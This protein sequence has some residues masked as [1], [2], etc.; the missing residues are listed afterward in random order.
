MQLKIISWNLNG[1]LSYIEN[2]SFEPIRKLNPD[3]VFLQ[4]TRTHQKPVIIDGYKHVFNLAQKD[5]YSKTP[6][7][8]WNNFVNT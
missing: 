4:E 1:L 7:L 8:K 6:V 5:G 3:I 2:N